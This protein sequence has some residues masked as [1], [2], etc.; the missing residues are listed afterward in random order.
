MS[1]PNPAQ[2]FKVAGRLPGA[3]AARGGLQRGQSLVFVTVTVLVMVISMLMTY[4]IG[5]L[6]NKKIKLQNTADAAAFSAAIAQARD[7]NFSAYMNR[8]QIANDVAVAQLVALRSWSENFNE[9][10]KD[11]PCGLIQKAEPNKPCNHAANA[12]QAGPMYAMWTFQANIARGVAKTLQGAFKRGA[13][14]FV[15]LLQTMNTG[16]V[17][18]QKIYHYST[19]LTVAQILGVDEKFNDYMRSAVGFDLGLITNLIK[20]GNEYNVVKMNDPNAALSLLGFASY[21]YDTSKWLKFTENRNPVGPWG[22][23][24]SDES[25]YEER[26]YC[27]T[28][29]GNRFDASQCWGCKRGLCHANGG[30]RYMDVW[31]NDVRSRNYPDDGKFDGP[32]KDRYSSVVTSSFDN[33]TSDRNGKWYLPILVDPVLLVGPAAKVPP[34][35]FF[36]LLFH[37]ATGVE[38][39]NDGRENSLAGVGKGYKQI[40]TWNN[41]WKATDQTTFLGLATFPVVIPFWGSINVPGIPY[42]SGL[43]FPE[44]D[45]KV[46]TGKSSGHPIHISSSEIFRTY[47]DVKDVEQGTDTAHQNWT[48]PS[49]LVEIELGIGRIHTAGTLTTGQS[50]G[51]STG[52]SPKPPKVTQVFAEGNFK[53]GNNLSAACMRAMAKSEAYFSRPTDLWPRSDQKTEYGSL[54]SPYWQAR[55]VATT[56]TDQTLS[57]IT[58]Y[59]THQGSVS[60][61]ANQ[62]INDFGVIGNDFVNAIRSALR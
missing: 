34:G 22:T 52:G 7:Y 62:L 48:S 15:P 51:C 33:F 5:Q 13:D 18:T 49:I 43:N 8:A 4:N 60:A 41:R 17:L 39:W 55:L 29:H 59:C 1:M 19:A 45:V 38:L 6:T 2:T 46:S 44:T 21:A 31:V 24:Q 9:T 16:F 27:S 40:G 47:R 3:R 50:S 42:K 57:L 53:L 12:V 54:Y 36:K 56:K 58:H 61:C 14:L 26:R 20:F 25:R 10:F 32:K 28:G 35:W 37:D 23:D 30:W 11:T